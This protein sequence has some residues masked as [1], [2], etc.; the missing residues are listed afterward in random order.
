MS[1]NG[2]SEQSDENHQA[3]AP[4]ADRIRRRAYSCLGGP[5]DLGGV[6]SAADYLSR[7]ENLIGSWWELKVP[8]GV[9]TVTG[10]GPPQLYRARE[11]GPRTSTA[12]LF[13]GQR[14]SKHT[15]K[16]RGGILIQAHRFIAAVHRA[17]ANPA[18]APAKLHI[19]GQLENNSKND[20]G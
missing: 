11:F 12:R 5:P 18:F 17:N 9:Q 3:L 15:P 6:A 20:I 16:K 14:L 10:H 2:R 8:V 1:T 7:F 13:F 4:C 19:T